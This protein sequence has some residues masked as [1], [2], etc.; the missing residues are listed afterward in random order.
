VLV[1]AVGALVTA[2][3]THAEDQYAPDTVKAAFLYRFAGYVEWPGGALA[4]QFTIAVLG[5]DG[6]A[7]ELQRLLP[8]HV[9]QGRP[10]QV[11][12][13]KTPQEIDGAQIVYIGVR[14]S[15]DTRAVVAAAGSRPVLIVT[16]D[17][18][19]LD[20][21]GAVNFMMVDRRVRFEVSLTAAD[22][23]GLKISSELLSVAARVEGARL[24]S[25]IFCGS[26]GASEEHGQVCTL[27]AIAL[28]LP[29]PWSRGRQS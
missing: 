15:A 22:R 8:D 20:E 5:A 13:I 3:V 23:S 14:H 16:D 18:R 24:R 21:G 25:S 28:N 1:S 26:F 10:A 4:P 17:E 6:V 27:P 29:A 9:I 2:A 11:R 12:V 19:G 7:S